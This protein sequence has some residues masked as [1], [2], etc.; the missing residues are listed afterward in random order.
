MRARELWHPHS[1]PPRGLNHGKPNHGFPMEW[2]GKPWNTLNFIE[3]LFSCGM[4]RHVS[5]CDSQ[6]ILHHI[7]ILHC[8]AV[9]PCVCSD[10]NFGITWSVEHDKW[11]WTSKWKCQCW[12]GPWKMCRSHVG[13]PMS[14]LENRG[15]SLE[16]VKCGDWGPR[17]GLPYHGVHGATQP[18][19]WVPSARLL[20]GVVSG[21]C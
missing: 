18:R 6:N 21:N 15:I 8:V 5:G 4:F 20:M 7:I 14:K 17:F 3:P 19:Y 13:F 1:C 2:I 16:N 11:P 9:R 10:C 12:R